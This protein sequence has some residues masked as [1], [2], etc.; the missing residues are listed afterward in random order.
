MKNTFVV[1]V[2]AVLFLSGNIWA[3]ESMEMVTYYPTPYASYSNVQVNDTKVNPADAA[4]AKV[5]LKTADIGVL[6]VNENLT[7]DIKKVQAQATKTGKST[8]ATGTLQVEGEYLKIASGGIPQAQAVN[9]TNSATGN[10]YAANTIMLGTGTGAKVF[11]Y[12]KAAVPGASNMV[13]RSITYYIDPSDPSKGKDTKTFLAID[14]GDVAPATCAFNNYGPEE[15]QLTAIYVP[16]GLDTCDSNSK[17]KF[18][19]GAEK[20][21]CVDYFSRLSDDFQQQDNLY[22]NYGI[23]GYDTC[24]GD[25][26]NRYTCTTEDF[27]NNRSCSDFHTPI[28]PPME[29][30]TDQQCSGSYF[31]GNQCCWTNSSKTEVTT[32]GYSASWT[33][34][35]SNLSDMEKI[36]IC[37]NSRGV[38]CFIPAEWHGCNNSGGN[39]SGKKVPGYV[40]DCSKVPEVQLTAV[41]CRGNFYYKREVE[42]CA[43]AI[44]CIGNQ[45]NINGVCKTPCG[46]CLSGYKRTSAQYQEDGACCEKIKYYNV[47]L[48]TFSTNGR[49]G[50]TVSGSRYATIYTDESK[51]LEY[52]AQKDE[53]FDFQINGANCYASYISVSPP[54]SGSNISYG[55]QNNG[56]YS[57]WGRACVENADVDI[58]VTMTNISG[59][60]GSSYR[61]RQISRASAGGSCM[62]YS[63]CYGMGGQ[64]SYNNIEGAYCSSYGSMCYAND[65]SSGRQ[66]Q[67]TFQC[68]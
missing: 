50:I 17:E 40:L 65:C 30:K 16:N 57:G 35:S 12:A 68:N 47:R 67:V 15:F 23:G 33:V 38:T 27:K 14:Q 2:S 1:L 66:D 11:P 22:G 34:E 36:A 28:V 5:K 49:C 9:I 26:L 39:F 58:N 59:G 8:A 64:L 13:W 18:V 37:N 44:R 55:P 6:K 31:V 54:S 25:S 51:V 19:C 63:S 48:N 52:Y 53:C 56:A 4:G 41:D 46:N 7:S 60:T 3:A 20:K 10:A 62:E 21:T 43:D 42:C 29:Y 32:C 24:N 45:V 61:W